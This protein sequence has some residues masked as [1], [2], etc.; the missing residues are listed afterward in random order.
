VQVHDGTS[1]EGVAGRDC[2]LHPTQR[3]FIDN[4]AIETTL[5]PGAMIAAF[6]IPSAPYIRRPLFLKIHQE[7]EFPLA[8]AA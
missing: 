8:A 2:Q 4:D 5:Q 1:I 3:A 7:S 6:W